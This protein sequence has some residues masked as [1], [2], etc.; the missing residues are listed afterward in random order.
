MT[1]Q[2]AGSLLARRLEDVVPGAVV[3][4]EAGWVV[5]AAEKLLEACRSLWG[6]EDLDLKYLVGVTAVDRL[7][8]FEVVY[9]LQ[10]LRHNHMVV[11]KTRALDHEAPEVP[12]VVPVWLGA[13]LQ[14]RE[15][16]DLMGI[17]FSGHPDL[18]R[19]F[20]WEGFPGYPLRKDF[21]W[22]PGGVSPGLPKFSGE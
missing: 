6:D 5:V 19:V 9:H 16:Y 14:E 11:V 3:E 21:L 15:V 8:H 4:A 18:R 20:L 7:D 12:S 2:L 1:V 22:M 10:S 17:R 13:L